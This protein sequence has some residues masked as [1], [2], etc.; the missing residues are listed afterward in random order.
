MKRRV[1]ILLAAVLVVGGSY[2]WIA[3]KD[4]KPGSQ[5]VVSQAERPHKAEGAGGNRQQ[6]D[7]Q[8][9]DCGNYL[10]L[11]SGPQLLWRKN[12]EE[13]A[14]MP[15][16]QSLEKSH[17]S[18]AQGLNLLSIGKMAPDVAVVEVETCDGTIARFPLDKLEHDS[19]RFYVGVNRRGAFKLIEFF[20]GAEHTI[21]RNVTQIVLKPGGQRRIGVESDPT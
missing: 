13:V 2:V 5:P 10:A 8:D 21:M 12:A 19:E 9:A 16:S 11:Y 15:E 1:L 3:G 4:S 7:E 18:G 6:G 14:A 17:Q 20:D